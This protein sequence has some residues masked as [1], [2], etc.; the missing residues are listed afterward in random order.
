MVAKRNLLTSIHSLEKRQT[1]EM[2][3]KGFNYW[4]QK[5]LYANKLR[6]Y[7]YTMESKVNQVLL[8][9]VW[10]K[11]K[12]V[13]IKRKELNHQ[14]AQFVEKVKHQLAQCK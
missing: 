1:V 8:Q 7:S 14:E 9:T 2:L 5:C 10:E 13:F 12:R 3:K 11:Y 4:R 6:Y